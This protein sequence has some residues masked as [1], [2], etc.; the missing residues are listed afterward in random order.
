[1]I[2]SGIWR[3]NPK[4]RSQIFSETFL[5]FTKKLYLPDTFSEKIL[6]VKGLAVSTIAPSKLDGHI[7]ADIVWT[8]DKS[9][10]IQKDSLQ[11]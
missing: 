2:I 7:Q 6:E 5:K 8:P 4:G 11:C 3:C 9:L 1:M 10:D